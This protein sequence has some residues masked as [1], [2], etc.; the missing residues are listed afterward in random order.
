MGWGVDPHSCSGGQAQNGLCVLRNALAKALL[1]E[2]KEA[3]PGAKDLRGWG[4]FLAWQPQ[5]ACCPH[6]PRFLEWG[7]NHRCLLWRDQTKA[8]GNHK[9]KTKQKNPN[10]LEGGPA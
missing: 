4:Q 9:N 8:K 10:N 2:R 1:E 6:G 5:V 3:G 7:H